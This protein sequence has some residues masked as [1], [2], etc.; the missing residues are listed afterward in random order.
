MKPVAFDLTQEQQ[1]K[2]EKFF[3]K[4][5]KIIEKDTSKPGMVLGQLTEWGEICVGYFPYKKALK[6]QEAV[7]KDRKSDILGYMDWD[8]YRKEDK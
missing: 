4:N 2:I 8:K 6:I 3:K 1:K 5:R 7:N